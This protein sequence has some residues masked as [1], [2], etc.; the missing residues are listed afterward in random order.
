MINSTHLSCVLPRVATAGPALVLV[1]MD[2][3]GS[4]SSGRS[5]DWAKASGQAQVRKVS[6][7]L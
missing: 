5:D 4:W 7:R 6:G 3:G 2:G 1:S